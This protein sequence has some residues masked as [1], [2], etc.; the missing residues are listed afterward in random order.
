MPHR[1]RH[2]LLPDANKMMHRPGR[3]RNLLP[4]HIERCQWTLSLAVGARRIGQ[5]TRQTIRYLI[6]VT[7]IPDNPSRLRLTVRHHAPRQLTGL[8][9][10]VRTRSHITKQL[11]GRLQLPGDGREPSHQGVVALARNPVALFKHHAHLTLQQLVPLTQQLRR[12][13]Q[14][15]QANQQ[16]RIP[17]L[18]GRTASDATSSTASAPGH[19]CPGLRACTSK[20]YLPGV[21]LR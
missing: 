4:Q 11:R 7:Q 2:R 1:I 8:R 17:G 10:R 15:H 18:V 6:G 21:S 16:I 3:D 9:R 13:C 14:Q 5:R 19:G 20:R 12:Q